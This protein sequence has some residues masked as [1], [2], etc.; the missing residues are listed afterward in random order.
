MFT[1]LRFMASLL[2]LQ[3]QF[4][5]E[6][7]LGPAPDAEHWHH[8]GITRRSAGSW[9]PEARNAVAFHADYVDSYLYNPLWWGD[10]VNGGGVNRILL[11]LSTRKHLKALHFDDLFSNTDIERQW[12][13][14]LSG[15]VSGLIWAKESDLDDR[16]KVS[17]AHNLIGASLHAIQD[18]YSHSN[19]INRG[20]RRDTTWF[21]APEQMRRTGSIYTGYYELTAVQGIY[22]H[23]SYEFQC[24]VLSGMA[25]VRKV[26][27]IVCHAASPMAES[28]ICKMYRRCDSTIPIEM[29]IIEGVK[30]PRGTVYVEP[31]INLDSRW[32]A[33]MGVAVRGSEM[34]PPLTGD[35]AFNTAYRLAVRNSCQWL[36]V[37]GNC[38]KQLGYTEFW[39]QIKNVGVN[40]ADYKKDVAPF[41]DMSLLPYLFLSAGPTPTATSAEEQWYLRLVIRT[42]DIPGANTNAAVVPVID[43]VTYPALDYSL[44]NADSLVDRLISYDDFAS[45]SLTAYMIGPIPHKPSRV[46]L[47]NTGPTLL[48]TIWKIANLLW[49]EIKDIFEGIWEFFADIFGFAADFIAYNRVIFTADRLEI[50]TVG[51]KVPFVIDCNGKSEGHYKVHGTLLKTGRAGKTYGNIPTNR[52]QVDFTRLQ[53][54]AESEWDQASNSDEPFIIG[55]I[56]GHGVNHHESW[57]SKVYQTVDSGEDRLIRKTFTVDVPEK[58]GIISLATAIFESDQES[59]KD[60]ERLEKDFKHEFSGKAQPREQD[61]VDV[62]G[63]ALGQQWHCDSIQSVAFRRGETAEVYGFKEQK[64][65]RWIDGG[66]EVELTLREQYHRQV[67]VPDTSHT[68][69]NMLFEVPEGID[70]SAESNTDSTPGSTPYHPS[71][72]DTTS[73]IVSYVKSDAGDPG[74]RIDALGGVRANGQRWSMGI[75]QIINAIEIGEKFFVIDK[76]KSLTPIRV[77]TS[78]SGSKYLRTKSDKNP[79]NNL[80]NLPPFD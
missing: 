33:P 3:F 15:T 41:E 14:Y 40:D 2:N 36:D 25:P 31:G 5:G 53:C 75:D 18:F 1:R 24:A 76:D 69:C 55:L 60:R 29:P 52:F 64:V 42:S 49:D 51:S 34:K 45:G 30:L 8:E 13:Q 19:W 7:P 47:L 66:D 46:A 74:R 72:F 58:Y 68:D 23:G 73:R 35:E 9:S 6:N 17:C 70:W 59:E 57:R 12:R 38:M 61:L 21:E 65:G 77:A 28:S 26:L 11:S 4:G 43:G 71:L 50:M 56:N 80:S 67:E 54:I 37:L 16:A 44:E 39:K 62:L 27:S 63:E 20:E 79:G 10:I 32:Q 48:E 78:G 22:P